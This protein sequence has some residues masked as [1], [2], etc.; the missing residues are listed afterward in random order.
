[1]KSK[2]ISCTR[3]LGRKVGSKEHEE[4]NFKNVIK[5]LTC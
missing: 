2:K 5:I 4:C 1:M 3:K